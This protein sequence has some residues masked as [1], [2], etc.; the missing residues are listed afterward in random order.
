MLLALMVHALALFALW[1]GWQVP[2]LSELE[3]VKPVIVNAT[4]VKLKARSPVVETPPAP[5]FE[6]VREP[7][8]EPKS[9]TAVPEP[10]AVAQPERVDVK[11]DDTLEEQRR[12]EVEAR[13]HD[14]AQITDWFE[15][16]LG[17]ESNVVAQVQLEIASQSYLEGIANLA[18]EQWSRPPSA[19][20]GMEV[21][22]MI[23]LVPTGEVVGVTIVRSSGNT[24]FDRSAEN[25]VRHARRFDV[26]QD[27]RLFESNFR[28]F[29]IL[30]RPEDLMR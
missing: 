15:Q 30:F 27:R 2:D 11:A 24:A 29:R 19:R 12:R 26:P 17:D 10:F 1:R 13:A 23:E 25:A 6:R 9:K 3:I 14:R 20:N 21:E 8:A 16:A 22:L 18:A 28:R 7:R 5:Q 4:L